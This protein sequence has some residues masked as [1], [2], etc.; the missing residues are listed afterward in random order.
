[1]SE[2]VQKTAKELIVFAQEKLTKSAASRK[3]HADKKGTQIEFKVGDQVAV[4]SHNLSSKL[5]KEIK[6]FFYL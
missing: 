5:N 2:N 4:K 3:K 6:K 1:V